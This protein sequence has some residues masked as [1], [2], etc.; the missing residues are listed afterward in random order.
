MISYELFRLLVYVI[1]VPI[2]L[3]LAFQAV[4]KVL[5]IRELDARLRAE[6]EASAQNPYASMARLYE[7]QELLERA[8]RGK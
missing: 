3:Y 1:G 4:R 2:I 5:A 6:E 8:R 7:A